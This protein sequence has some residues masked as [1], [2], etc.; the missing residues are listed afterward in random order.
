ML[1][2][3]VSGKTKEDGEGRERHHERDA[4]YTEIR[5][6]EVEMPGERER[7]PRRRW[8]W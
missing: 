1:C 3:Q 4:G 7:I 2:V 8:V 6:L 5:M